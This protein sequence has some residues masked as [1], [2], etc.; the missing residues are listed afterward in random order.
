MEAKKKPSADLAN[1]R[2]LFL[3]V[4]L[5][6]TLTVVILAFNWRT[7]ERKHV[8]LHLTQEKA[9]DLL[10]IPPTEQPP[11]PPPQRVQPLKVVEIPDEEELK[12]ELTI[13]IDQETAAEFTPE[14]AQVEVL[15]EEEETDK[16][17]L[18]VE[19]EAEFDGGRTALVKFVS[20]NLKYPNQARRMG[21]EGKV[22]LSAV[23][24]K[25]GSVTNV[26]VLKGIGAGCDEEAV[27][28]VS[29]LPNWIP[30]K[31]RGR[32]VRSRITVPIIFALNQ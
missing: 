5:V 17:F 12:E 29:K 13:S 6:T 28:V 4:G 25:D 26:Q 32:P 11:P 16:I 10:E 23:I 22:F 27:R 8:G 24:E 18:V 31:Q 1:M 15:H 30:A 19:S 7:A 3:G 9:D 20:E 2:P 21:I 14:A